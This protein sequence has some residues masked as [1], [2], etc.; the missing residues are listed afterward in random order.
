MSTNIKAPD[1][2]NITKSAKEIVI[3]IDESKYLGLEFPSTTRSELFAFAMAV[4]VETVPTKLSNIQPGGFI[5]ESSIDSTTKALMHAYYIAK[6]P[7]VDMID[8]ATNKELVYSIAQ[9][10]ANTGF[11]IIDDYIANKKD[12]ELIWDIL[13][14]LDNQYKENVDCI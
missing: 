3:K 12:S 1:R 6:L 2:I 13:E 11:E 10:Y 9:E 4:G 5:L 14:E 8:S 7:S